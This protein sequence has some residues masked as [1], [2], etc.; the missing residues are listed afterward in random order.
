MKRTIRI[1]GL[2]AVLLFA[3]NAV[4]LTAQ[5]NTLI[6]GDEVEGELTAEISEVT[7]TF[8]GAADDVVVVEMRRTSFESDLDN[9]LVRLIA[10]DGTLLAD[11]EGI[12]AAMVGAVLPMDGDYTIVATSEET[13]NVGTFFMR[14]KQPERLT[15]NSKVQGEVADEEP[16]FYM[17]DTALPFTLNYFKEGGDFQP[18]VTI[19]T[20][21]DD[22][23]D[24]AGLGA[25][26]PVAQLN[27]DALTRGAIGVDAVSDVY[28]VKIDRAR[29]SVILGNPEAVYTLTL[30]VFE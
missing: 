16:Q 12:V 2:I 19:N 26:E 21:I 22:P 29:F 14:L 27:G 28:I 24:F 23:E 6:Y 10:P 18:E 11:A 25:L 30:E 15:N 7:Y 17:I 4:M 20:I 8:T 13:D 9:P 1:S 5:D 3:L